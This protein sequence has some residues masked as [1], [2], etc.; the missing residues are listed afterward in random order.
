MYTLTYIYKFGLLWV[1][2]I[3]TIVGYL[4]PNFV[5]TNIVNI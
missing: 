2:D 5:F 3:S 4:M 1:Y